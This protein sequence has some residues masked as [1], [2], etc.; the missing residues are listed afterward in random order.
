MV[1]S[2]HVKCWVHVVDVFL[3][4]LL[5]EQLN[6]LTKPLEMDDFTF[7]EEL[8]DIVHIRIIAESQNIVIGDPCFLLWERIA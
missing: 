7:P 3:V 2:L 1:F 8:D 5:T 4:E 6:S